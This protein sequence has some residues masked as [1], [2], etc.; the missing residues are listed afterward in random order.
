MPARMGD[1]VRAARRMGIEVEEGQATS[2]WKFRRGMYR[3]YPIPA[4]N[5]LKQEISDKYIRAMCRA[6]GLSEDE[7]RKLL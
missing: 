3:P 4:H 5:G 7:F 6:L 1:I 2:H